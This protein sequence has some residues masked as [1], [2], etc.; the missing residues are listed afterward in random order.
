[1]AKGSRFQDTSK[2]HIEGLYPAF[3]KCGVHG[4]EE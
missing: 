1:M 4:I 3:A 2:V